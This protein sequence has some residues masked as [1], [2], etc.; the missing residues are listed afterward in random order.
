[1]TKDRLDTIN[2]CWTNFDY[3]K[4]FRLYY[5]FEYFPRASSPNN[6]VIHQ[7]KEE[8]IPND[9]QLEFNR[10]VQIL[11]I[12]FNIS[13]FACIP[14]H[15]PE[16]GINGLG[17]LCDNYLKINGS[18]EVFFRKDFLVRKYYVE[19]R[20]DSRDWTEKRDI[21]SILCNYKS[22]HKQNI[23][24]ID[25]MD[26]RYTNFTAAKKII[27]KNYPNSVF[28]YLSISHNKG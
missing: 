24:I 11:Q 23:L 4:N 27:A 12:E 9:L 26:T 28:Y 15:D 20:L 7:L 13:L 17:I 14:S 6:T 10:V 25:D 18:K 8:Y 16:N 19:R 3:V 2:S 21:D 1:M 22:E 5:L